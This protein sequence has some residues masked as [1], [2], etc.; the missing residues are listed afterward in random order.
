MGFIQGYD[1]LPMHWVGD[2][3]GRRAALTPNRTA[4]YDSF[5]QRSWHLSGHE[6]AGLPGGDL[7]ERRAGTAQGRCH[8]VDLPQPDRGDRHLF[9]LRKLGIIL[10]PLSNV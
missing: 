10:A 6:R 3:A 2:W 7:S 5:T 9:G 4:L 8:R 1:D